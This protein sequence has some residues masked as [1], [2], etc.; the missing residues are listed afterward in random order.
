MHGVHAGPW[1]PRVGACY[2]G[3]TVKNP[4]SLRM[5]AASLA[6]FAALACCLPSA[7]FCRASSLGSSCGAVA[8]RAWTS[9]TALR[10]WERAQDAACKKKKPRCDGRA[11]HSPGTPPHPGL[12]GLRLGVGLELVG[13]VCRDGVFL[14]PQTRMQLRP[15]PLAQVLADHARRI[16]G[17]RRVGGVCPAR[18]PAPRRSGRVVGMGRAGSDTPKPHGRIGTGGEE[19]PQARAHALPD[20]TRST[21]SQGTTAPAHRHS[22][23]LS[24]PTPTS[25][26]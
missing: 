4:D 6:S 17:R 8:R 18:Q 23:L 21:P 15:P 9:R 3:L 19:Q 7:A 22:P 13:A 14:E 12:L 10:G 26:T 5:P 1:P 25:T 24:P 20:S 11:N 16:A 2:R